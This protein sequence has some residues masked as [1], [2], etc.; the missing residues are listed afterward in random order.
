MD[1]EHHDGT[2]Q[3]RTFDARSFLVDLAGDRSSNSPVAL[4]RGNRIVQLESVVT[5]RFK[6]FLVPKQRDDLHN[7]YPGE[8]LLAWSARYAQT[9]DDRTPYDELPG[10]FM[11]SFEYYR[12]WH[13]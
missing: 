6:T 10:R 5:D 3:V 9:Y 2:L 1:N 13:T 12:A 7:F 8:A 11:R 4:F